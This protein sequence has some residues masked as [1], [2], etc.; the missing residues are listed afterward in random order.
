MRTRITLTALLLIAVALVSCNKDGRTGIRFLANSTGFSEQEDTRT[1][2]TGEK[3]NKVER[4]DWVE[5]D[6][7][8]IWCGQ[9]TM[10]GSNQHYCDYAVSGTSSSGD[11]VCTATI[12]P[13]SD[14]NGMQWGEGDHTF[15]AMYPSPA[16]DGLSGASFDGG[17]MV[18]TMPATQTVTRKEGTGIWLPDMRYA[19]MLAFKTVEAHASA[20]PLDFSPK[21][22]AFTFTV[23][24]ANY[25]TIH[26]SSFTLTSTTGYLT[27]TYTLAAGAY[28]PEGGVSNVTGGGK[29]ITVDLGSVVLDAS[30]PSFTFTVMTVPQFLSGLELSFTGEEIGTRTLA[31]SDNN[32]TPVPF[33]AY[34][35]YNI[36]GLSFPDGFVLGGIDWNGDYQIFGGEP[37]DWRTA[38][39][40][41]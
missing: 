21:Y 15:Y 9:A 28:T 8:R 1:V 24:K 27:G 2:F 31:L 12:N 19:P 26:M 38:V 23:N 11:A 18:F 3:V 36:G 33:P 4:I 20:V 40:T 29:S 34:K 10:G 32:G 35:K 16:T 14:L 30:T 6:I 5:G 37:I 17:T 25:E 13:A 39:P 22:S 41:L 7:I